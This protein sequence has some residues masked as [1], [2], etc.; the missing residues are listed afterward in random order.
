MHV[1]EQDVEGQGQEDQACPIQQV[2]DDAHADKSGVGDHIPSRG[3]R[4]AGSVHLETHKVFGKA[5]EDADGE[6][7]DAS[8]SR[9]ALG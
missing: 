9:Q 1:L 2:G 6:V 5:A 7:E 4:V 8:D 3:R